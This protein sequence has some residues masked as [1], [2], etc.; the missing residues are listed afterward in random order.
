MGLLHHA[1]H[2]LKKLQLQ[3]NGLDFLGSV[4]SL[5]ELEGLQEIH[6]DL[7][8]F[9]R[10]LSHNSID[11]GKMLPASIQKIH[12][13][14]LNEGPFAL[15]EQVRHVVLSILKVQAMLLPQLTEIR[16]LTD[17]RWERSD[18][19]SVFADTSKACHIRGMSFNLD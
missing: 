3:S 15:L 18:V 8:V 1:K 9:L 2:S 4:C 10:R 6:T 14:A 12:L 19:A 16:L 11:F 5:R 17:H 7:P 13:S